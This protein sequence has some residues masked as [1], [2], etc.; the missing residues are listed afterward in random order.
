MTPCEAIAGQ[1]GALFTCSPHG[2]YVRVRT[3]FLYPD[4]DVVDLFIRDEG[5]RLVVSDLGESLRWLRNQTLAMTRPP[6]Q[7]RLIEDI[8]LTN[9]VELFKGML[10]SRTA[11]DGLADAVMRVGQAAV[12][13]GDLWFTVQSR[14]VQSATDDVAEFLTEQSFTFQRSAKATGRSQTLWTVDF[15]VAAAKPSYV[16]VLSTESR[17]SAQAR[18]KGTH[19]MWVDLRNASAQPQRFISLVDDTIANVWSEE[20]YRLLGDVSDVEFWANPEHFSTSLRTPE[21]NAVS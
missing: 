9:D 17:A 11:P 1:L 18:L 21:S 3:P 4:G 7:R 2:Q 5:A 19:T 8:K 6:R 13:V 20:D 15:Q 14:A 12:R 10:I 16:Q